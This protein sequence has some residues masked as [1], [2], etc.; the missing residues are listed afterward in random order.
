MYYSAELLIIVFRILLMHCGDF[1][2]NNNMLA[3]A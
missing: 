1:N 3:Y 2:N